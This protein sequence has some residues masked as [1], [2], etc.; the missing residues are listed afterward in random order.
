V[1][2]AAAPVAVANAEQPAPSRRWGHA[3]VNWRK[4]HCLR[5]HPLV[6]PNLYVWT[7]A[8]GNLHR[9]CKRCTLDSAADR[10]ARRNINQLRR[11]ECLTTNR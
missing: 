3:L 2:A 1:T 10:R 7:D 9:Q 8:R 6:D 4:T 11:P 5:G